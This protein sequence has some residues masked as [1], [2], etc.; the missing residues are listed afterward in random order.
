MAQPPLGTSSN[1]HTVTGRMFSP[2]ISGIASVDE[3]AAGMGKSRLLEVARER[4][5]ELGSSV[6][7]AH[8]IELEQGCPYGVARQVFERLLHDADPD[9]RA[10][11]LAGA[12]GPAETVNAEPALSTS[13]S[14]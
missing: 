11:W 14:W 5:V 13:A 7:A 12:A 2:S 1:R 3:A 4:A 9:Q 10:I 6:L 8:D